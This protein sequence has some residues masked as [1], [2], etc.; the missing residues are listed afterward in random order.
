MLNQ[1]FISENYILGTDDIRFNLILDLITCEFSAVL[2][3]VRRL[4]VG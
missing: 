4:N 2:S 1:E 3:D